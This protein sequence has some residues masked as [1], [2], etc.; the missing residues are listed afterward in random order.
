MLTPK[1]KIASLFLALFLLFAFDASAAVRPGSAPAFKGFFPVSGELGQQ[2]KELVAGDSEAE[3]IPQ[4]TFGTRA[5]GLL[6]NTFRQLSKEAV[7]FVDNFAA[8][9]QL[10]EWFED[11]CAMAGIWTASSDDACRGL[12]AEMAG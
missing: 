12:F 2:I 3:I 5:L 4:E 9:P 6:L 1:S 7:K 11:G 8:L 10:A